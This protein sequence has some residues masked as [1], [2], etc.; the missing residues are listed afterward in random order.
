VPRQTKE[1][2]PPLTLATFANISNDPVGILELTARTLNGSPPINVTDPAAVVRE[3]KIAGISEGSYNTPASVNLTAAANAG[4]AALSAYAK[5]SA[6]QSMGNGW[7]MFSQTGLF[8]SDYLARAY[9]VSVGGVSEVTSESLY[10]FPAQGGLSLASGEA[11]IF[12]F[13]SKPPLGN[14]GFWS[15]TAY[16]NDFLIPNPAGIYA[17]GDRSNLTYPDGSLVY[18]TETSSSD[19]N[20]QILV[21]SGATPP[22]AN[23]THK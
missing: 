8:G 3:L 10:A 19:E 20:F 2:I 4:L 1:E 15:L 12:T 6:F 23:W 11:Y 14:T 5:T 7:V 9:V 22:P 16:S 18:G 21:Q 17:V 13:S